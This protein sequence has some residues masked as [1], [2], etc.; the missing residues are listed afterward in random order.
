VQPESNGPP[1]LFDPPFACISAP[2]VVVAAAASS[3]HGGAASLPRSL[4][5]NNNN[6]LHQDA[7]SATLSHHGPAPTNNNN[8]HQDASSAESSPQVG[9]CEFITSGCSYKW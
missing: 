4:A 1:G 8:L 7:S 2:P 5:Q 3:P 9:S 6:D